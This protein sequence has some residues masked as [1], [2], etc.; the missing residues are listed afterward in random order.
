MSGF[1]GAQHEFHL[2]PSQ[3]QLGDTCQARRA[4]GGK[5]S[6]GGQSRACGYVKD[7]HARRNMGGTQ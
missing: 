2:G 6:F 7:A 5:G 3:W 1:V 4:D